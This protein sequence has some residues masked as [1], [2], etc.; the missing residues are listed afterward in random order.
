MKLFARGDFRGSRWNMRKI[1]LDEKIIDAILRS[2]DAGFQMAGIAPEPVGASRLAS[3]SLEI[4]AVIGMVGRRTGTLTLN[5]SSRAAIYLSNAFAGTNKNELNDEV[6]DAVA[7]ITNIIAGRMKAELSDTNYGI[8][9]ISCPSIII[10][11]DYRVYHFQGFESASVEFLIPDMPAM[12][13]FDR[14]FSISLALSKK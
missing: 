11:G 5:I 8:T 9:Q 10:G 2:T 4:S 14:F 12:V 3:R 1:G 13:M 6:L 7:E